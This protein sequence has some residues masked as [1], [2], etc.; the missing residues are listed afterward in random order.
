[1]TTNPPQLPTPTPSSSPDLP[2]GS[3]L[4]VADKL[5]RQKDPLTYS[6]V[7][8]AGARLLWITQLH[9]LRRGPKPGRTVVGPQLVVW[10]LFW[11][12]AL[13]MLRTGMKWADGA[14]AKAGLDRPVEAGGRR[15]PPPRAEIEGD[16]RKDV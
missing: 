6:L 1:M 10:A 5:A 9:R 16:A 11:P 14:V 3:Q 15:A 4:W 2:R 8:C 7:G 12:M 13:V